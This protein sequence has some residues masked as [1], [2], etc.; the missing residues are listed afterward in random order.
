M[1]A[2]KIGQVA[3]TF[4][5]VHDIHRA[6]EVGSVDE[7]IAARDLRPKVIANLTR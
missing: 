1:R 3:A 2:E 5:G 6:V 4:D 7:V